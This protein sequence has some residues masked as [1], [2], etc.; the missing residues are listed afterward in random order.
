MPAT[1][2]FLLLLLLRE[3]PG[4]EY[5]APAMPEG[6]EEVYAESL[7]DPARF[8]GRAAEDI[9]WMR[10]PRAVLDDTRPPVVRWFPGGMLNTCSNALDLHVAAGR[11]D[12]LALVYDSPVTGTQRR[13]RYREL[14]DEVA[15]FAGALTRWRASP[16]RCAPWASSGATGCCS[17]CRWSRRR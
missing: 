13:F 5:I 10:R 11:G 15:R 8:W 14:R 17:T 12:Q 1:P 3:A 6:Y 7:E 9:E 16:G 4:F 2:I